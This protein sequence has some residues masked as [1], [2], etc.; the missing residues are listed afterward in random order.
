MLDSHLCCLFLQAVLSRLL[1]LGVAVAVCLG[2]FVFSMQVPIIHHFT[3]D[4]LV[5]VQVGGND[6]LK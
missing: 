6:L 5:I 4:P 3:Q 1:Q 2:A